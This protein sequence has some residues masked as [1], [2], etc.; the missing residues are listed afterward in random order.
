MSSNRSYGRNRTAPHTLYK[1]RQ[2]P[3]GQMLPASQPSPKYLRDI[4]MRKSLK[5]NNLVLNLFIG[6]SKYYA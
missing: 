3:M 1:R 2:F 6:A 5:I 4:V